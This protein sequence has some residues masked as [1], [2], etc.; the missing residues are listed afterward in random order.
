MPVTEL[1]T[2]LLQTTLS[3]FGEDAQLDQLADVI[4]AM[5]GVRMTDEQPKHAE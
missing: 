1:V 4:T 3:A 5:A 2:G